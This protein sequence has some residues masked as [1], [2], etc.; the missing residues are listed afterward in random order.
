MNYVLTYEGDLPSLQTT[1]QHAGKS[2]DAY[3]QHLANLDWFCEPKC[4]YRSKRASPKLDS[5]ITTVETILKPQGV[6]QLAEP[7]VQQSKNQSSTPH[8]H[9]KISI[10]ADS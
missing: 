1:L 7:K 4:A 5:N 10:R 3:A 9:P 8:H 2:F 6:L